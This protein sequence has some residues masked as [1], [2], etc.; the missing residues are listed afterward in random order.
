[1]INC[2]I[3][4]EIR[5]LTAAISGKEHRKIDYTDYGKGQPVVLIHSSVSGNR[6]WRA[7]TEELKDSY[8]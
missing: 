3:Y 8:L 6:Q 5:V 4:N 2:F 7:L 1:M